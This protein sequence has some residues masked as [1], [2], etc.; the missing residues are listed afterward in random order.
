MGSNKN[1]T[2]GNCNLQEARI[3]QTCDFV[4]IPSISSSELRVGTLQLPFNADSTD[5]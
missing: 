5:E 3:C 1:D 2:A 4:S